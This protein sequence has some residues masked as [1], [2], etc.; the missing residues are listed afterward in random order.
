MD[1]DEGGCALVRRI[2]AECYYAMSKPEKRAAERVA[3]AAHVRC[4]ALMLCPLLFSE[5]PGDC[6]DVTSRT[7]LL[8]NGTTTTV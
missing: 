5:E 3:R 4:D 7:V 1:L 8:R 6:V 2:S